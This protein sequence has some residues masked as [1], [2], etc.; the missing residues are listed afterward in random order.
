MLASGPFALGPAV[1]GS[2]GR[3][4]VPRSNFGPP[5]F[6]GS[7]PAGPSE[8][9]KSMTKREPSDEDDKEL[10]SD[11]DDANVE[12]V[13]IGDVRQLDWMAPEN[14]RKEK[15]QKKDKKKAAVKRE[16]D[17]GNAKGKVKGKQCM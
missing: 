10:Y 14:L 13:D 8:E 15:V 2:S 6:L 9:K 1:S 7:K 3:R 5:S 16:T 11:P 12:I 17:L 4:I